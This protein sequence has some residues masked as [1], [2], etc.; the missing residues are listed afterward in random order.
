M[1]QF[2][3]A[4]FPS[5]AKENLSVQNPYVSLQFNSCL[6]LYFSSTESS[7]VQLKFMSYYKSLE[8]F[9]AK[10]LSY[11][12]LNL[13]LGILLLN[14]MVATQ[15]FCDLPGFVLCNLIIICIKATL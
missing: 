13:D 4:F 11:G 12:C 3:S 9:S 15:I 7:T 5:T 14:L 2:L 8:L 10:I 1:F 6:A